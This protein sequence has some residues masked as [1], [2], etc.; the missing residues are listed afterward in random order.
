MRAVGLLIALN[1]LSSW[2][3][4]TI[5]FPGA[6]GFGFSPLTFCTS[7]LAPGSPHP[8][9]PTSCAIT[10]IPTNNAATTTH[11]NV[12]PFTALLLCYEIRF[13]VLS[14]HVQHYSNCFAAA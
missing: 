12:I 6:A 8:G 14:G 3:T 7:N 9:A 10:G 5:A 11:P 1:S 13:V 2:I 4:I